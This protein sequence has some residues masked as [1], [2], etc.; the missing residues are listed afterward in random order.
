MKKLFNLKAPNKDHNQ[1]TIK[2]LQNKTFQNGK[3]YKQ[4]T[5]KKDPKM[6]PKDVFIE[7]KGNQKI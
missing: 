7:L 3:S 2:L 1:Q 6:Y 5:K 4:I